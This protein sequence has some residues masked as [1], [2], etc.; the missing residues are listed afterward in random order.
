[1]SKLLQTALTQHIAGA[2][3]LHSLIFIRLNV[4]TTSESIS[5][6]DMNTLSVRE[7]YP[8][9]TLRF[10]RDRWFG[11]VYAVLVAGFHRLRHSKIGV[12]VDSR[13]LT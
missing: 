12:R 8:N 3:S 7:S 13:T 9:S 2:S 6:S 4:S 10:V 1:M 5:H 11:G